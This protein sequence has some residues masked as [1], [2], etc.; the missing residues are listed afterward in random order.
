MT[1]PRLH[2][3]PPVPINPFAVPQGGHRLPG[4]L[5]FADVPNPR[6]TALLAMVAGKSQDEVSFRQKRATQLTRDFCDATLGKRF[7]SD[8]QKV[9]E[10]L[11]AVSQEGLQPEFEV[12]ALNE[13]RRH[14]RIYNQVS[15]VLHD[16]LASNGLMKLFKRAP[17]KEAL[18]YLSVG[19]NTY[20]ATGWDYRAYGMYR[21]LADF[22]NVCRAH[23]VMSAG[24]I[25]SVAVLGGVFPFVGAVS[26]IAIMGW[27]GGFTLL[28]ELKAAKLGP[29]MNAEK[30]EHYQ[31]SGENMAAFLLTASGIKGIKEGRKIGMDAWKGASEANKNSSWAIRHGKGMSAAV[32]QIDPDA[33][34]GFLQSKLAIKPH[35]GSDQNL[36]DRFLFV[37]GLFDNVLLPFNWLA[38]KLSAQKLAKTP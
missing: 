36:F 25:G 35:Q 3:P 18:D 5:S 37:V 2:L 38:D 20:R 9:L 14:G 19:R 13:A 28:H 8:E 15:D 1:G 23:P 31:S 30:A 34:P 26:G 7:G 24:V 10:T 17:R 21:S 6:R 22:A 27:A 12:A 16:E 11:K 29:K 33:I 32:K 4:R